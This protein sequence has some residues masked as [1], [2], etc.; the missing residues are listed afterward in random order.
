MAARTGADRSRCACRHAICCEY[1]A[2]LRE[3]RGLASASI[4]ALMWEARNFLRWQ[5]DRGGAASLETLSIVDVDLY[6]DM[7]APG[8]RRKSLADVA[9]RLRSVVRYLHRT[10]ASRPISRRTSSAP[11]SMPTKMCPR[12]WKEQIAAVL[13][14]RR[15]TDRRGSARL[16][17]TSAAC[18][19]RAAQGEICRLRLED[20]NWRGESLRI[21]HTKTNA[22]SYMPLLAPVGE[23]LLDYL[24]LGAPRSKREIFVRSCAPYIA[25]TNLYGMIRGRLA[26]AGVEPPGKRGP[27][28]FRHAR[29]V[30]MLRASVPQKII[31]DVLGHRS[32]E[33]TNAYLKLA[34]DDLRAVALDVPGSEVLS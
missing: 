21:R 28:V 17:D 22:Y 9:E 1:E 3:E 26:A 29:A 7:R 13:A 12:R 16:C 5:F 15:R 4:A 18:H 25:M 10:G 27:H 19:I 2:W 30:E 34:T 32:T 11:C 31:G 33:S 6:M 20:V 23:A 8:L 24:R 14:R